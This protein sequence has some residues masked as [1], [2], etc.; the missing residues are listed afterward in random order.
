MKTR[1]LPTASENTMPRAT[2]LEG[3]TR[4]RAAVTLLGLLV[5]TAAFADDRA[6]ELVAIPAGEYPVGSEQARPSAQPAHTV[7]LDAFRIART[8]VTNAAFARYLDQLDALRVTAD[9]PAGRV[10][11][12]HLA[13][14]LAPRLLEGESHESVPGRKPALVGLADPD[15]RIALHDGRFVPAEG[16]AKHPVTEV[17]W[18]GARAYCQWLG[19]R[20]PTEAEWEAAARGRAGRKYPW[21][22]APVTPERA[23]HDR[24]RGETAA[25]GTH[26]QGATPE[27]VHD[28]AGNL[29]EWTHTLDRPY[30][31]AADDGREDPNAT[32]E[33]VTRGGD[34]L[35]DTA[36]SQLTT[37]F[38]AGFSRDPARGHR[39][40]GFR[41]AAD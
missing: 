27:G 10:E 41:C 21:G 7:E 13:G 14:A 1:A 8:E 31:Y 15:A 38:R 22:D 23:V 18:Y 35:F 20:L 2:P 3:L 28:L 36:P 34:Y 17:T 26:P 9:A 11:A 32:G 40:I 29:A 37:W 12:A 16:Y 6:G 39:H 4:T 5:A 33:R 19:R 30:P 25:V 24:R